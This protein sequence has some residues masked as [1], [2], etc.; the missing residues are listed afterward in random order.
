MPERRVTLADIAAEAGV[1]LATV[2]KVLNGRADV[3]RADAG[4]RR[5]AAAR[6]T[7]TSAAPRAP[8]RG[9]RG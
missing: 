1:S 4:P 6:A 8:A 2:S 9:S 3:S 5:A 7:A